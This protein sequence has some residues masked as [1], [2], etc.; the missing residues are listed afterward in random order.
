MRKLIGICVITLT[1]GNAAFAT[2]TYTSVDP[3]KNASELTISK[4]LDGIYGGSFAP[5]DDQNASSFSWGSITA[6]RVFDF[7][8]DTGNPGSNLNLG[9][10]PA[11]TAT[12]QTWDDGIGQ[13]VVKAKYAG[14]SQ[15]FGYTDDSGYHELFEFTGADGF[16]SLGPQVVDLTGLTWTWD[17]SDAGNGAGVGI[18]HWSSLK[19]INSDDRDH[20]ITYEITGLNYKTWLLFWDDQDENAPVTA[21]DPDF[22]DLVIEIQVIPAPGALLLGG[23]GV[24]LIGWLRKRKT[25]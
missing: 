17:R 8:L 7:D 6:T 21:F 22:N 9:T 16:L 20:M 19:S 4:I 18:N 24:G 5:V 13:F 3:P 1:L 12:D 10:G 2:L 14:F 23:L 25:L 11:D 15:A